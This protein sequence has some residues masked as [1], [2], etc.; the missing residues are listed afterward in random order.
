VG[1]A[2]VDFIRQFKVDDAIIGTS[3]VDEDDTLLDYDYRGR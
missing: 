1:E 3:A 2:A